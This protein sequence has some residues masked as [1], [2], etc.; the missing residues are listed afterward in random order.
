MPSS[1]SSMHSFLHR[2]NTLITFFGSVAA[3]LA[4][5]TTMTGKCKNVFLVLRTH[6]HASTHTRTHTHT[7]THN[8]AHMHTHNYIHTHAC[9]HTCTQ[10][11]ACTH[12]RTHARTYAR[13]HANANTHA[14]VHA[15]AHAQLRTYLQTCFINLSPR[16][17]S[18]WRKSRDSCPWQAPKSRCVQVKEYNSFCTRTFKVKTCAVQ[19]YVLSLLKN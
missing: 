5:A 3:V 2:G 19:P 18:P 6:A 15:H 4:L 7:H 17:R 1:S 13:M 16:P 8:H 9:T 14:H 10:T 11:N 12:V